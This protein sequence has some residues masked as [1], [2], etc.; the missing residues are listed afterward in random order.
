MILSKQTGIAKNL[1]R[2]EE[3][4]RGWLSGARR[5]VILGIG[6]ALAGDDAVGAEVVKGLEGRTSQIV[7]PLVCW[8]VP[9]NCFGLARR[10]RASHVLMVDA[11]QLGLQAG[12]CR[13]VAPASTL[14]LSLSTHSSPLSMSAEYLTVSIGAEVAL[15]AIQPGRLGFGEGLSEELRKAAQAIREMLRRVLPGEGTSQ[16]VVHGEGEH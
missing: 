6:S 8:T 13:L 3:S 15:L 7:Y 4:L 11:A 10:V 9:E 16:S 5:I 2:V 12:A 1:E 14:G